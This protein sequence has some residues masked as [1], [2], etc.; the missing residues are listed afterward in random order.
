MFG[1]TLKIAG[2][3]PGMALDVNQGCIAN[4]QTYFGMV[5]IF[6]E[7]GFGDGNAQVSNGEQMVRHLAT[8]K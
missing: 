4:T 3:D 1:R 8:A 2:K 6:I 7:H 5:I